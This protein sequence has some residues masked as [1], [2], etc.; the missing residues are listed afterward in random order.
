MYL[1]THSFIYFLEDAFSE[2]HVSRATMS[3]ACNPWTQKVGYRQMKRQLKNKQNK[4]SYSSIHS[5]IRS[6]KS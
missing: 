6:C 4:Y 2:S 5:G 1:S 3:K